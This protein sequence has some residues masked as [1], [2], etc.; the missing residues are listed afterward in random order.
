MLSA[1]LVCTAFSPLST[2]VVY[3]DTGSGQAPAYKNAES[4]PSFAASD[5]SASSLINEK[6]GSGINTDYLQEDQLIHSNGKYRYR[7]SNGKYLKRSWK[8]IGKKESSVAWVGDSTP[9][10]T[11]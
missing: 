7:L 6:N 2:A 10:N 8:K 1:I 4:E 11:K 5:V 9:P 3:A